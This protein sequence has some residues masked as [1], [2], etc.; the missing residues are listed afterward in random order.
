MKGGCWACG[1]REWVSDE[2][3]EICR[4]GEGR[5]VEERGIHWVGL[6]LYISDFISVFELQT[7]FGFQR[8][9]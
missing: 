7:R 6:G 5:K 8:R 3:R 9:I 4:G 2:R 1:G